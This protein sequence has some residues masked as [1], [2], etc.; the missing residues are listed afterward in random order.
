MFINSRV[1]DCKYIIKIFR[2]EKDLIKS[3]E[4]ARFYHTGWMTVVIPTD[5]PKLV[6]N[7]CVI[8]VLSVI[9]WFSEF[10]V[11]IGALL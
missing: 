2:R 11:S 4:K 1:I 5:R 9:N 3:Y 10:S 7:L 6:Y 8:E